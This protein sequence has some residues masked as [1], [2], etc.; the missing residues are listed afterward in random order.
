MRSLKTDAVK[1]TV[2]QELSL[3]V[4]PKINQNELNYFYSSEL[5]KFAQLDKRNVHHVSSAVIVMRRR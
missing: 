5:E 3:E 1:K 4:H 2:G